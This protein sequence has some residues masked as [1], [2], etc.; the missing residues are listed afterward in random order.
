MSRRGKIASTMTREEQGEQ[1][2]AYRVRYLP[3]QIEAAE[4]KLAAL[5]REAQRYGLQDLAGP[6]A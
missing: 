5:R 1:Y 4:R 2:F 3:G 6:G